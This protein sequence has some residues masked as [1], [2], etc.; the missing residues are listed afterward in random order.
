[1]TE[2]YYIIKCSQACN[3]ICVNVV[4]CAAT[5][6]IR[7]EDGC[8]GLS[9]SKK[10]SYSPLKIIRIPAH[11][12][13]LSSLANTARIGCESLPSANVAVTAT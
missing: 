11:E 12:L 5:H 7:G 1:M 10:E 4:P 9:T 13:L 8:H 6:T 2:G 3:V